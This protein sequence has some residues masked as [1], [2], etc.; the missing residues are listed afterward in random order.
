MTYRA[1]AALPYDNLERATACLRGRFAAD[2]RGRWWNAGLVDAAGDRADNVAGRVRPDVVRVD[3][4]G[5]GVGEQ[6][7][8][9]ILGQDQDG[10][11]P[12]RSAASCAPAG[13]GDL[14]LVEQPLHWLS[15]GTGSR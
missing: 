2:G 13:S 9:L 4:L 5:G 14:L 1:V 3:R 15:T 10:F 12:G 6:R 7:A 11:S 8:E